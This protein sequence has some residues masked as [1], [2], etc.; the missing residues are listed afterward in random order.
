MRIIC[1]ILSI[2][3]IV[4]IILQKYLLIHVAREI[5]HEKT[6]PELFFQK[7]RVLPD[8]R[9]DSTRG[10]GIIFSG[11]VPEQFGYPHTP[12]LY[13]SVFQ[14]FFSISSAIK[15]FLAVRHFAFVIKNLCKHFLCGRHFKNNKKEIY[16]QFSQC[17]I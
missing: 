2:I 17:S 9:P 11:R 13:I 12:N 7:C 16:D 8:T 15:S 3:T 5:L 1:L 10:S 6:V 4:V 14:F